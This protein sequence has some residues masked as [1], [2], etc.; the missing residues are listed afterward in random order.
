MRKPISQQTILHVED[1][2][3]NRGV[4]RQIVR[5]VGAN[6]VEAVD[7]QEGVNLAKSGLPDLILMDL[8]LPILDG[9]KATAQLK[10][11]P[12]TRH[13]P[14]IALTAHA[15]AGD[16]QRARAAGCDGYVAKPIDPIQFKQLLEDVL[17]GGPMP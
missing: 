12:N 14:V 6:L 17:G 11:D 4:V 15:M 16:E 7:G 13:I 2:E 5:R 9:W 8:S 1:L 3:E 10:A